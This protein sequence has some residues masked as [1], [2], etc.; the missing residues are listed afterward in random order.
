MVAITKELKFVSR[1]NVEEQ[2][3][4]IPVRC[5][6]CGKVIGNKWVAYQKLLMEGMHC[7]DAMNSLGLKRYCCRRMIL[8][9]IDPIDDMLQY[10]NA[11]SYTVPPP[12]HETTE[13]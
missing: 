2:R 10:G 13:A 12:G 3:M 11:S 5:Y 9:H 1:I 6:T 8:T 4:L 7:G